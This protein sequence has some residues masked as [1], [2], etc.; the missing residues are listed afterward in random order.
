[1]SFPLQ[2]HLDDGT[3]HHIYDE[4]LSA[5]LAA[6]T[7]LAACAECAARYSVLAE[8]IAAFHTLLAVTLP[9]LDIEFAL[10]RVQHRASETMGVPASQPRMPRIWR[11]RPVIATLA[12]A[13]LVGI[14]TLT[15][16]GSLAENA[17]TIFQPQQFATLPISSS[18]LQGL[19]GLP[20][21]S[22]YGTMIYSKVTPTQRVDSATQASR[23]TGFPVQTPNALP[24]SI[25][26][27]VQYV[28]IGEQSASFTFS[29]SKAAVAAVQTHMPIPSMPTDIDGSTLSTTLGPVSVAVYGTSAQKLIRTVRLATLFPSLMIVQAPIPRIVSTR[30]TRAELIA[31]LLAQPGMT[32]STAA[33]I[34]S[35]GDLSSTLPLPIP[36][37]R[38]TSQSVNVQGVSGLAVGDNTGLGTAIVWAKDGMVHAVAGILTESNA[39]AIANSLR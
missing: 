29:A 4:P 26:S 25:P 8:E 9:P 17:I 13:A 10:A 35:I 33:A 19:Q 32:P 16:V 30:A 15:P 20:D 21:L 14:V 3:L 23:V 38:A 12:A 6:Q 22:S 11:S 18:T 27:T 39:L 2:Q 31:Y 37:D 5:D 36:V 24:S 34:K 1:M 7:H 28:V